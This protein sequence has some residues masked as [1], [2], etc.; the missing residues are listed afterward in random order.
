MSLRK[1][2]EEKIAR[3]IRDK[4][5]NLSRNFSTEKRGLDKKVKKLTNTVD[6]MQ[7]DL[8][9]IVVSVDSNVTNLA[10]K[11]KN[12]LSSLKMIRSNLQELT[13][14]TSTIQ[15]AIGNIKTS[16]DIN[17]G[18]LSVQASKL[19]DLKAAVNDMN[20]RVALSACVSPSYT[21]VKSSVIKFRNIITSKGIT[22][23][24]LASFRSSGVFV[25]EVPGLYHISVV[26]M[27]YTHNA[28]FKIYKTDIEL[29][30]GYN[31]NYYTGNGIRWQSSAA[32]GVTE[33]QK[34]DRIDI[35]PSYK[36]MY[37]YGDTGDNY[38]CLTIVR[39]K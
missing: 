9:D 35:K 8:K 33:L 7:S 11:L 32:I 37:I 29:M 24:H 39:V 23:Q 27:S 10:E 15:T 14:N 26:F 13:V 38:S 17:N 18:R 3:E 1:E 31:N 25:C 19:E 30:T 34:G 16:A 36:S 21:A 12:H 6:L 22:Y 4:L 28:H 2:M 5:Q 20:L